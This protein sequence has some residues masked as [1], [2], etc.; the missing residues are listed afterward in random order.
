MELSAKPR[1]AGAVEEVTVGKA[2]LYD[3]SGE[4]Q[5]EFSDGLF[6]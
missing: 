6:S 3:T 1:K 2:R 4:E 5:G